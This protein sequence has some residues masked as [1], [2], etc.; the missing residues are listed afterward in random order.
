MKTIFHQYQLLMHS[1]MF[2]TRIPVFGM[3]YQKC[4][5]NK[6]LQYFSL[7]GLIIGVFQ[8]LIFLVTSIYLPTTISIIIMMMTSILMTGAFHEDGLADSADA[9]WGG[10][11]IEKRKKILKD[12][13]IGVYGTIALIVICLLKFEIFKVMSHNIH[14]YVIVGNVISRFFSSLL[15]LLQKYQ[16]DQ[17]SKSLTVVNRYTLQIFLINFLTA[18]I[19][20]LLTLDVREMLLSLWCL[21]PVLICN[22]IIIKKMGFMRGDFLGGTQQISEVFFYLLLIIK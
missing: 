2:F 12:S 15:L 6:A 11:T 22:Q 19:V 21:L 7:I 17:K 1:L 14:L 4:Y 8:S 5:E 20:V 13:N 9:L 10:D 18:I 16:G 3:R